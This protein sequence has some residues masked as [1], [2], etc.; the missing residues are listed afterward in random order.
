MRKPHCTDRVIRGVILAVTTKPGNAKD[1]SDVKAACAWAWAMRRY[2]NQNRAAKA[3]A[4]AAKGP[5]W[6]S[7]R[8]GQQ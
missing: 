2:R 1:K 6:Q 8:G 5:S 3:A 7:K 4:N